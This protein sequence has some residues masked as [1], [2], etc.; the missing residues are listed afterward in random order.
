MKIT[1]ALQAE[2]VVYH[3]LFDHIEKTAPH[4]RTLAEVRALTGLLERMLDVHSKVEDELLV[5]P[6]E[7]SLHQLGQHENFHAEHEEMDKLLAQ[8]HGARTVATARKQLYRAVTLCR[9]HF[10]KEERIVFPLAEKIL[11]EKT[12]KELGQ[13]WER[14]RKELVA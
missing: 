12:L 9:R 7:P 4:L 1:Q 11:S 13:R 2:H 5:A 6:L 3:N 8:I 14:Q 10:D